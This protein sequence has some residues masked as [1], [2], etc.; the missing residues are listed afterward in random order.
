MK[1]TRLPDISCALAECPTWDGARN[2]LLWA[3]IPAGVIHEL[4]L[5]GGARRSWQLPGKVGSFGLAADQTLVVACAR[6]IILLDR[7]SGATRHLASVEPDLPENRFNDGKVG[8]DGAFWVGTMDEGP[9]RRPVGTL[10]RIDPAGDVQVMLSGLRTSN[11]LAW[12][13]DGRV[14]YHADSRGVWIDQWDFD[15]RTGRIGNRRRFAEPSEE[16]GRPDGAAMDEQGGYWSAGISAGC[17]NRFASNGDLQDHLKLPCRAPTMPCFA[18]ADMKTLYVTSLA[19]D[20]ETGG[21]YVARAAVAGSAIP[22]F[23]RIAAS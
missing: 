8:P 6:D 10:Y 20:D 5:T 2:A 7:A 12:S 13:P 21:I 19:R 16:I 3:D 9:D 11:G 14:L 4:S 15:A 22:R 23:G 1:F 18:G 17:L